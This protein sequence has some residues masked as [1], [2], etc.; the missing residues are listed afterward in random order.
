MKANKF[1]LLVGLAFSS[2]LSAQVSVTNT[3]ILYI[4]GSSDILYINGSFTNSSSAAFTNNGHFHVKQN[5]TN[6]EA[7][8]TIGVGTL[9]L[10]GT[11]AQIVSGTQIF[12]TRDFISNNSSGI[13]LNSD[14][15]ISG[16]HT[17]SA[18]MITSSSTPNYLVYESGSSYSGSGD[19]KHVNGW[20][21]KIG[22]T[23]FTF[24]VGDGIY[25]RPVALEGLSGASEFNVKYD[26]P[27]PNYTQVQSPIY[28]M[29]SNEYWQVNQVSGG[30]AS[31]H[32]NWDDSK[33]SFGNY[34]VADVVVAYYNGSTWINAGGT[35]TGNAATTGNVTSNSVSSFGYFGFGSKSFPLPVSFISFTAQRKNNFTELKW[36]TAREFNMDHYEIQRSETGNNFTTIGSAVSL[37]GQAMQDYSFND[38]TAINKIAYYRILFADRDGKIKYSRV[39]AV[40]DQSYLVNNLQILN[41]ARNYITI[42]A[43]WDD[44]S[45]NIV[46]TNSA[47]QEMVKTTT[48]IAAG[49]DNQISL[50][51]RVSNGIYFIRITGANINYSGKILIY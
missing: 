42:R 45:A 24:P 10:N 32:L 44:P 6:D 29:N 38:Y 43:K 31:V 21:K 11:S 20:V 50:P 46:I 26:K 27:T 18:G 28:S 49:S 4:T 5:L 37:N 35:A 41:P 19:S 7:A 25:E 8:M 12:K 40:Y 39:V 14:L 16:V 30:S 22:S 48:A 51:A 13:T 34:A 9:Y 33:V 47:G 36:T 3:G 1:L 2:I 17:F 15:S 23:D